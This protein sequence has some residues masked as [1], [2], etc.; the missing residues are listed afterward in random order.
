[1]KS[2]FLI[3]LTQL[4]AERNLPRE[5][6]LSA[7]E[8]ALM[9]AYR[10]D[11]ATAGLNI[12]VKLDPGT[13][14]VSVHVL[15]SVVDEIEDPQL[16][17]LLADARKIKSDAAIGDSVATDSLPHSA[18]RI[19]AQTA[20]QVVMQRLR[21]AERE[22]VF[23]EFADKEGEVFSVTVQRVDPRQLTVELGR[24]EAVLPASE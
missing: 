18:G 9:S 4:A 6:V 24:A 3:A 14:D 22:L 15:K 5:I 1:M 20:K 13:G 2:D 10:K 21:E 8:A 19:A 23:E 12:S 7:I 17:I 16:E 11:S